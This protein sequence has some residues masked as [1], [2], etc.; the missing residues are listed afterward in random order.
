[1]LNDW[2][3]KWWVELNISTYEVI[4]TRKSNLITA[5][6][7]VSTELKKLCRHCKYISCKTFQFQNSCKTFQFQNSI[8]GPEVPRDVSNYGKRR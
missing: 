3:V 6:D 5:M 7:S 4:H 8:P 2:I 1:M